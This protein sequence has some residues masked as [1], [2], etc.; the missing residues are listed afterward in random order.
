MF[1][2]D[3][4]LS[5]TGPLARVWLAA[6]MER[7][8][9][10]K[11]C[12]QAS[13][14]DSIQMLVDQ[15]SAPMALRLSGQLLLG[16]VRIYR[17]KAGYLLDDCNEALLKI[18]MAFRPGNVDLPAD[19]THAANPNSLVMADVLTELDL[20]VPMMD[21]ELLLAE[22]MS[23]GGGD[24]T[25]LDWGTQSLITDSLQAPTSTEAPRALDDDGLI[26]DL[27]DDE[28]IEIGRRAPT[29]QDEPTLLGDDGL[30]LDLDDDLPAKDTSVL[31]NTE[32]EDMPMM[33][34]DFG[35]MDTTGDL[36]GLGGMDAP[37]PR[38]RDTLS[39]LSELRP[40][41]ERELEASFAPNEASLLEAQ[42]ET[43][44]EAAQRVKRRK[45]LQMDGETEIPNAQIKSQQND[46]S[47]ILKPQSFLPRDPMLLAL[48]SMQKNGGFISSI[49]GDGRNSGWAPELRDILSVDVVK[50][51]GELKR[52][53]D[54]GIADLFSDEEQQQSPKETARE[55][56]FAPNFGDDMPV[57][58]DAAPV[59]EIPRDESIRALSAEGDDASGVGGDPLPDFDDTTYPDLHPKDDGPIS[60]GTQHA[61]HL[62]REF[63]GPE[64]AENASSRQKSSALL[65]DLIPEQT[66]NRREATKM[67]FEVLVLAT[68]DAVKVEQDGIKKGVIGGNIR[69]R[70]KRGLYG[71]WAEAGASGTQSTQEQEPAE[72][73]AA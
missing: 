55:D 69:I 43:I 11:D 3:T 53:R 33:D 4:L 40:S 39:P 38:P 12:V 6:N 67:F 42:E 7:K 35:I 31:G 14:D 47:K 1:Y 49:L 19:Q 30:V 13:L 70:A 28:D 54:S 29:V 21:P 63:F 51:S 64:G 23:L 22:T 72:V 32:I 18:K 15:N 52:K 2:S 66:T 41:V 48:M 73:Q 58:D 68:K 27:D 44:I 61:V 26:L 37:T 46:H 25:V 71:S 8:L 65:Q 5:K 56:D 50:R 10:K 59:E 20:L 9:S 24:N 62:L 17:R 57:F 36:G 60:Q 16:V 34:S 45:L